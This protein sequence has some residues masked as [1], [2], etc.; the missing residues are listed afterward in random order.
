MGNYKGLIDNLAFVYSFIAKGRGKIRQDDMRAIA[1]G[2]HTL[3]ANAPAVLGRED[4]VA[5]DRAD[6][7]EARKME[8]HIEDMVIFLEHLEI[9]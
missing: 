1:T 3:V 2:S 7:A 5:D 9:C 4:E 8:E 6:L